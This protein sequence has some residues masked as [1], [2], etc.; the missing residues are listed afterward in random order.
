MTT[1]IIFFDLV[2]LR[3]EAHLKEICLFTLKGVSVIVI[4]SYAPSF[5]GYTASG[6]SYIS[7]IKLNRHSF[8]LPSF[9]IPFRS[10][11]S[12]FILIF[13]FPIQHPLFL[14]FSSLLFITLPLESPL[15]AS[16]QKFGSPALRGFYINSCYPQVLINVF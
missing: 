9:P 6:M 3:H 14:S 8:L 7:V 5:S 11:A 4:S 2:P 10:L 13:L 16:I 15:L 1:S 12:P